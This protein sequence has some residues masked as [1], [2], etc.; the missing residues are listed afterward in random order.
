MIIVI[1]PIHNIKLN[2]RGFAPK[3]PLTLFA[4]MKKVSKKNQDYAR[5]AL[6]ISRLQA[7][8]F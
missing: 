2:I 5:F 3:T 8:N 1:L 6:K 7:E 4:L